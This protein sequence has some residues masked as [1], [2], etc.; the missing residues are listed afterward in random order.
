MSSA[1]ENVTVETG[2]KLGLLNSKSSLA[3][4]IK[5]VNAL[6]L[7]VNDIKVRDRGPKSERSMTDDDAKR[8]KFGDLK[9]A[10]H[11]DAAKKLGLSYGQIYSCRGGYTF[12][13]VKKD[14]K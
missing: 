9:D 8:V 6:T 14:G 2:S 13:H 4:V 11:K 12:N 10:S 5:H 1:T 7:K 3:D